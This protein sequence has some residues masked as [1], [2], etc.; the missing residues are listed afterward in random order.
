MIRSGALPHIWS[1]A[2]TQ[3]NR[4]EIKAEIRRRTIARLIAADGELERSPSAMPCD[5][6][7]ELRHQV[8]SRPALSDRIAAGG[9]NAHELLMRKLNAISERI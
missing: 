5:L 2:I 4:R 1:T 9:S 3:L 8:K 6:A 7:R